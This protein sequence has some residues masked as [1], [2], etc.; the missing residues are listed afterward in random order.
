METKAKQ[1][2]KDNNGNN[3]WKTLIMG[4]V[5]NVLEKVT[6]NVS[7]RIHTWTK[8]MKRRALG[9]VLVILGLTYFLTG[10]SD[11][12]NSMFGKNYPGLGYIAVGFVIV[13]VGYL[14]GRK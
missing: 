10:L 1:G 11:Y 12:A 2:E 4:F 7:S 5:S 9:G 13:V 8:Q 6:D 3:A 14:M